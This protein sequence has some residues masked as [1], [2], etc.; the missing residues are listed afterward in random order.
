MAATWPAED[1]TA[2]FIIR[3]PTIGIRVRTSPIVSDG[4]LKVGSPGIHGRWRYRRAGQTD[5]KRPH[6]NWKRSDLLNVNVARQQ[7]TVT[8]RFA[9]CAKGFRA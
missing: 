8:L 1:I 3:R 2:S 9:S 7:K 5:K 4:S 6:G